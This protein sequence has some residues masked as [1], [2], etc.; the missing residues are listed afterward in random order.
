[1]THYTSNNPRVLWDAIIAARPYRSHQIKTRD[2]FV[3][4]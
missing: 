3:K 1:M 4:H 2:I